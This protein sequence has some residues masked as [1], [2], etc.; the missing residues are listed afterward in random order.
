MKESPMK[1]HREDVPYLGIVSS[2]FVSPIIVPRP[3]EKII[4]VTG[5]TT[6]KNS[7][8]NVMEIIY[9]AIRKHAWVMFHPPPKDKPNGRIKETSPSTEGFSRYGP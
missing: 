1:S 5:G 7:T 8:R 3:E 6:A 4:S 2:R 9:N